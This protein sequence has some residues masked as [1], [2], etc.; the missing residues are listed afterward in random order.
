V[1]LKDDQPVMT[2]SEQGEGTLI[3]TYEG[4]EARASVIVASAATMESHA[5]FEREIIP[6]FTRYG[7][8]SGG[9]HGASSGQDGFRLSLFGYDPNA[10]YDRITRELR[11]RRIDTTAPEESLLLAKATRTTSHRGGQ[12][13]TASSEPYDD[14]LA[15]IAV[16]APRDQAKPAPLTAL[17]MEPRSLL[18]APGTPDI[19]LSVTAAYEDGTRLDVT[20]LAIYDSSQPNALLA[21]PN[22]SIKVKNAGHGHILVR[23][24]SLAEVI[25]F[26]VVAPEQPVP[27]NPA[28]DHPI[29]QAILRRLQQIRI[30]TAPQ[31]DDATF[32]R[33][34]YLDITGRLPDVEATRAF[35]NDTSP[36]RRNSLVR[37]LVQRPEFY[38]YWATTFAEIFRAE[39]TKLERKGMHTFTEYLEDGFRNRV[40]IST[41]VGE[42]LTAEG[43]HFH[44]PA[45][46]FF[47]VEDN[48]NTRAEHAAQS[49]LGVR[50]QCAQ[51]HHH[52]FDRWTMDDYYGFS[53]FFAQIATK[54]MDDPRELLV[55]NRGTGEA[56]HPIDNRVVPPKFLGGALPTIAKEADRRAALKEWL[57]RDDQP[58][59][60]RNIAN[61][62]FARFFGRGL[63]EPVDDFRSSN[64]PSHPELLDFLAARLRSTRY[65]FADLAVLICTS[66]SYAREAPA[67]EAPPAD[68]FAARL[69]R[70]LPAESL[71]DAIDRV[72]LSPTRFAGLP[73]SSSALEV[74]DGLGAGMPRFLEIF[75][76]PP[77]TSSCSCDRRNEPTLTQA[78]HLINSSEMEAKIQNPVGRL[79]SA[80]KRE[81]DPEAIM[82]EI[83][84]AA[85]CR[86]PTE[87]ERARFLEQRADVKDV[88]ALLSDFMWVVL[89]S[90]EFLF[91]H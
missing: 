12:R 60:S 87:G 24:G 4:L 88:R 30:S 59:F 23:Y 76:R 79:T 17:H 31:C 73:E 40:P 61:R 28:S 65:D 68:L 64:P 21:D 44:E 71:L 54:R 80:L 66:D 18:L 69:P 38:R 78:L 22:G 84:L 26:V 10:D 91:H 51:C 42:M 45:G 11:G 83:I 82:E 2:A 86:R 16:G 8:N 27:E 77:R 36:E 34:T 37:D 58:Q 5:S 67:G 62:I 33:R 47:L 7:C 35:L 56:R 32:L 15:W 1:L 85:Y 72:T 46:S 19:Q 48:P 14:L 57:L 50:I 13:F 3:A 20:S 49:L 25:P 43:G 53:A 9:C 55:Y 81:M 63:V 74:R 41:L 39:S 52:P 70:R 6:I 90:K 75:G 29:D 89:N